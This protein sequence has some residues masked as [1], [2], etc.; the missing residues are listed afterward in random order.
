MTVS[1]LIRSKTGQSVFGGRGG[2]PPIVYR[3]QT[4][5]R[6]KFCAEFRIQAYGENKGGRETLAFGPVMQ[7]LWYTP[8]MVLLHL[9][10]K[11]WEFRVTRGQRPDERRKSEAASAVTAVTAVILLY[12]GAINA[13]RSRTLPRYLCLSFSLFRG[14]C[15]RTSC[16]LFLKVQRLWRGTSLEKRIKENRRYTSQPARIARV[17][18]LLARSSRIAF[19][20]TALIK[21]FPL[22]GEIRVLLDEFSSRLSTAYLFTYISSRME[23]RPF[24][25]WKGNPVE[26]EFRG[27]SKVLQE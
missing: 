10:L 5:K 15:H 14:V 12:A 27:E 19:H 1:L 17:R 18:S 21:R 7:S 4:G 11:R 24:K 2:F 6:T 8:K 25:P 26:G 23:R 20:F 22:I 16:Y 13:L 9:P 3:A